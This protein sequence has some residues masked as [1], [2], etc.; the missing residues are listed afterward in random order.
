MTLGFI[1]AGFDIVASYECWDAAI[2]CHKM[3]FDHPVIDLDLSDVQE[4]VKSIR[5]Y[6][7]DI[8]IGGP[9]C[10]DFSHAGKRVESDRAIL[11][12]CFAEIVCEIAPSYF[13]MENVARSIKSNAYAEARA[14]FKKAG[15]GLTERVLDASFCGVP[16]RR[17]RS[18]CI[19][20]MGAEESFMDDILNEGMSESRMTVRDYFGDDL[21]VEYYYRHPRTYS[22]RGI[23]S[24]DEP[25]PTIRG[26]NRSVSKNYVVHK[27]D[28]TSDLSK[29]R[30]LSTEE[31]ARIQTFP[32]DFKWIGSKAVCEQMIGNAVP[33]KLAEFVADAVSKHATA[34][35]TRC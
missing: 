29:V 26:V 5:T 9:P 11:T 21:G 19:G 23:F 16:Q 3:N 32:E 22:R 33:V 6:S 24:V 17:K 27:G 8:I 7:P 10:Q 28:A 13:V 30:A 2:K 31:R 15:Y 1:N 12:N 20:H 34:V 35:E 25:A 18:I 14:L 4:A